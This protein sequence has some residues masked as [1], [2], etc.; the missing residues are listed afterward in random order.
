MSERS[1]GDPEADDE[2]VGYG[3]PPRATRFRPGQSGNPRGRP[4]GTRN[5]ATVIAATLS[6]KV[7]INEN[8]KRKRITK[9]DATVKQLVNRAASG[10]LRPIQLLFATLQVLETRTIPQD[11]AQ[12]SE[13]D[14]VAMVE[15]IRRLKRGASE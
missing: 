11:A 12:T 1:N 2:K 7:A 5:L 6:E 8:G 15:L 14:E 10:D 3:R 4:K 13:A 9:L